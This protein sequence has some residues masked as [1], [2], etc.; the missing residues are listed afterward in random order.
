MCADQMFEALDRKFFTVAQAN[1]IT[2]NSGDILIHRSSEVKELGLVTS[3]CDEAGAIECSVAAVAAAAAAGTFQPTAVPTTRTISSEKPI[4]V[5]LESV[6]PP[7]VV[8]TFANTIDAV[9]FLGG[10]Q[11]FSQA[12]SDGTACNGWMVCRAD[13]PS[14]A[15]NS[16]CIFVVTWHN[17]FGVRCF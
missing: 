4:L 1:F 2:E 11:F 6:K 14:H 5:V 13:R 10:A 16:E 12:L 15:K 17:F 9:R 8:K 7:K 3:E